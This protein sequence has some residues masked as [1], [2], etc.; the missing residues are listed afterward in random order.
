MTPELQLARDGLPKTFST[1]S[2]SASVPWKAGTPKTPLGCAAEYS[3][4]GLLLPTQSWKRWAREIWIHSP[5][6][7]DGWI[8]KNK[9]ND[10]RKAH[11]GTIFA[12]KRSIT[13]VPLG[14]CC[15]AALFMHFAVAIQHPSPS[16]TFLQSLT[17]H[18]MSPASSPNHPAAFPTPTTASIPRQEQLLSA[19]TS[20][21][22][23]CCTPTNLQNKL[24]NNG[25]QL[26]VCLS[27]QPRFSAASLVNWLWSWLT[28]Q[29]IHT[30]QQTKIQLLHTTWALPNTPAGH[31]S[32][33]ISL[34][35]PII[36]ISIDQLFHLVLH[37]TCDSQAWATE[38]MIYCLLKT[39]KNM[40]CHKSSHH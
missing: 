10:L 18:R 35:L 26:F 30:H 22:Q 16:S 38:A 14:C 15:R 37:T 4:L 31:N 1:Y 17:I 32:A 36:P 9:R 39:Q 25:M 21:T 34:L 33:C 23:A 12:G 2:T 28:L 11:Q 3:R 24:P 40:W 7:M 5:L 8:Q 19:T 20:I 27:P 29:V 13:E 6:S